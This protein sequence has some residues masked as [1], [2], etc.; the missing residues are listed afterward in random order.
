MLLAVHCSIS[1][2][3]AFICST[4]DFDE[5]VVVG[6][7]ETIGQ[8]RK[9]WILQNWRED[10][11]GM[12][13][14]IFEFKS[15]AEFREYSCRER[16]VKIKQLHSFRERWAKGKYTL[17]QPEHLDTDWNTF[18]PGTCREMVWDFVCRFPA[19]KLK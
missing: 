2:Q 17:Q 6:T 3:T 4:P 18:S 8:N 10:I 14:P 9:V 19:D 1:A 7:I 13:S 15:F 5:H 11:Y 12:N 16:R